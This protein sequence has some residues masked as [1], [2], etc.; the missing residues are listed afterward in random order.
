MNSQEIFNI[1]LG[2]QAPWEVTKIYFQAAGKAR[3]LHIDIGFVRGSR[4]PDAKGVF[5]PV[6]DTQERSWRHL[7]FFEHE[8]YLH[9]RV[10]RIK[11]GEGKVVQV[12]VPWARE[13]SGF[14]LLFEAFAM[15]LIEAEMPVNKVGQTLA[16]YPNRIWTIFNYWIGIAYGQADHSTVTKLGIDETSA[17]K[18]HD[19]VTVG[20][21][22]QERRVIHASKGKDADTV[23][24]IREHLES[25]GCLAEQI[26]QVCMDLSPAF[27]SGVTTQFKNAAITFDRFHIKQHLNNAMDE[28]RKRERKEHD[29][30]KHHKYTFLKNHAHLTEKQKQQRDELIELFPTL[31]EAYRFKELFN[32]F[33]DM[34]DPQDAEAFLCYWC[35]LVEESD[36]KPFHKFVNLLKA[37][38]SGIINFIHSRI[39][40]GILEGI[41]SKIQLAKRRARGYRNTDNFINMIY[42]IAGKLQ[43][44]YPHQT[45]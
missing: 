43:F 34:D 5:C 12:A 32:D 6:H 4:F 15:S 22:I 42:F 16:E 7:N 45:T 38:W 36:I 27:I 39:S 24:N 31:G 40:N 18:G 23:K 13:G 3:T 1:A 28:V 17:R 20:V 44:N 19:Y 26:E 2:L 21:D 11:T 8:C 41:N 10:P 14:T 9:C 30:L 37:H 25:K 33:W 29:L 35:D